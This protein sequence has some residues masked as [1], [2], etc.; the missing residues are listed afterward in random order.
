[1]PKGLPVHILINIGQDV[2]GATRI[3]PQ[4]KLAKASKLRAEFLTFWVLSGRVV[5]DLITLNNCAG[6]TYQ[7]D[8]N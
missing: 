7:R 3:Y 2:N 6:K 5:K 1:M 8:G 4:K